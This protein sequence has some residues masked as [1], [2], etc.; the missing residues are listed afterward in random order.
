MLDLRVVSIAIASFLILSDVAHGQIPWH[1][2][3][4]HDWATTTLL[5]IAC[6]QTFAV[7]VAR[8]NDWKWWVAFAILAYLHLTDSLYGVLLGVSGTFGAVCFPV[9]MGTSSGILGLLY[10][11]TLVIFVAYH[12]LLASAVRSTLSLSE[13]LAR[14]FFGLMISFAILNLFVRF[15]PTNMDVPGGIDTLS[16]FGARAVIPYFFW[17][18][19]LYPA[20]PWFGSID[21]QSRT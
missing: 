17:S 3:T 12:F 16:Y 18:S 9:R 10:T 7:C 8:S 14:A 11:C 15:A 2:N 1:Y 19:F 21:Q 4:L 5:S 6:G 20:R 13:R